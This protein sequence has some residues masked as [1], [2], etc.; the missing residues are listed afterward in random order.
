MSTEADPAAENL[1]ARMVERIL[2]QERLTPPVEHALRQVER[3][4]YVP[5]APLAEAYQEKAVITHSFPDGTS[6]SCA[7]GPSIV[8]AMLGALQVEPGHRILEIGAGTGY[9]AALLATLAGSRGQVTT[10]DINEDVTAAARANLDATGFGH[11]TV[12]TGDGAAGAAGHGFYDRIIVT[13]G[14]WD[15][16]RA[17][18]DQLAPGG[19][20]GLPLR[21]RGTTPAVRCTPR[22]G[23]W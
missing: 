1:R 21:W 6:L 3:H 8:A 16:P 23:P 12:L 14:A 18:R 17:W 7:S 19:G 22:G 15:I 2:A 20:L 13:V 5:S 11:V 4:R 10:I 9:N